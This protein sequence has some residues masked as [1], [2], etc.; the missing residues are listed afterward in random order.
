LRRR[1]EESSRA[2]NVGQ[3][4]QPSPAQQLLRIA[5]GGILELSD[6]VHTAVS[7][8]KNGHPWCWLSMRGKMPRLG[9]VVASP[10]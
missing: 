3:L 8:V 9:Q 6:A 7:G 10:A 2:R 1:S 4:S 5:S